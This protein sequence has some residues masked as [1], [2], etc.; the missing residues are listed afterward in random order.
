LTQIP[1][2]TIYLFSANATD[3]ARMMR[4]FVR[5]L[6][7]IENA[8]SGG[9]PSPSSAPEFA[10][11]RR[12]AEVL[13]QMQHERLAVLAVENRLVDVPG[14]VPMK[15]LT[16]QDL[17]KISAAGQ[18]VRPISDNSGYVLTQSRPVRLLR[19]HPE[20]I[21]A[22]DLLELTRVLRLTPYQ[23]S[24]AVEEVIEGQLRQTD[25]DTL[26][27]KI[28]VTT[29]SVLEVMYLLSKTVSVPAE[30]AC[31][32]LVTETRNPDG[33]PFNW[34]DVLGDLFHVEVSK[35]KPKTAYLAVPFRGYWYYIDDADTS[36]KITLSMFTDL[37]RLQRLG[38][39]EGQPLLTLPVGR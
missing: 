26:R 8:G 25:F 35:H 37:F 14:A 11:F 17:L 34:D 23:E 28:T 27:N 33:S 29:R 31:S 24:Y 21:S 22:P 9:G 3:H 5:N 15:T 18:G 30:H 16:A 4:L 19:I 13:S 10:E 7:G 12:A 36:S 38:A 2:E 1:L 39:A 6:N 20:A 32:G